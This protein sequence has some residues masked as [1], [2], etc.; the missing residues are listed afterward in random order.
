MSIEN[1][2]LPG[3]VLV[4]FKHSGKSSV[5]KMLAERLEYRFVDIDSVIEGMYE[6]SGN[7]RK[8]VREIYREHGAER[9]LELERQ[10]LMETSGGFGSVI[11]FGGA[12]PLNEG[13]NRAEFTDSVFIY[14]D[15]EPDIL[16]ERIEA[17]GFPPFYDKD[18]PR[19]SFDKM[20]EERAKKYEEI[21]DMSVDNSRR[22]VD[23]TAAEIIKR[24][25]EM[26]VL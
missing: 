7:P 5:G 14:L 23:E 26:N 8:S 22:P 18:N 1:G 20:F 2:G 17:G 19:E 9:F 21:A 10:A 25:E 4:G 24:L 13:F 6:G 12:T 16:F 3:L 15:V 11:A